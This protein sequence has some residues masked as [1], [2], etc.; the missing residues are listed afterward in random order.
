MK[1]Y[2]FT[3][4]N[5][6]DYKLEELIYTESYTTDHII[7]IPHGGT[8]IP[9]DLETRFELN[10]GISLGTDLHTPEIYNNSKGIVITARLNRNI[11]DL[12]RSRE[13]SKDLDA[14]LH[15]KQDPFTSIY[16]KDTPQN[17]VPSEK[18]RIL[19]L[20]YYDLYHS[21]LEKQIQSM[22]S[23]EGYAL[24]FDC[25]SMNPKG[26]KNA[27]DEGNERSDFVIGTVNGESADEYLI[28]FFY[29]TLKDKA[30]VMGLTVKLNYPYSGGF[31]TRHH[32]DPDKGVHVIQLEINK[33]TYIDYSNGEPKLSRTKSCF[34]K[35]LISETFQSTAEIAK[36]IIS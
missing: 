4:R 30:P 12:N 8:L 18:D 17:N 21:N 9:A 29:E 13:G 3:N 15:L 25:H 10:D 23:R 22:I 27:P 1:T 14:P 34:M 24:M 35:K 2:D 32:S 33:S 11:I 19:L 20:S 26:L 28:N 6:N 31:I 7:S 16:G 36:E 5:V